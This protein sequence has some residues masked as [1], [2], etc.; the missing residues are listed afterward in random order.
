MYQV[1]SMQTRGKHNI[2]IAVCNSNKVS[3]FSKDDV[4]VGMLIILLM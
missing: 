3:F 1:F 2:N 4:Y